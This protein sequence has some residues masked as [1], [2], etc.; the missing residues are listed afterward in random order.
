MSK[1]AQSVHFDLDGGGSDKA[2]REEDNGP[3]TSTSISEGASIVPPPLI[4]RRATRRDYAKF[5]TVH[6]TPLRPNWEPGQEPGLDPTKPNGGRPDGP[7]LHE[8][9]Q[10]TVVDYTSD[11][12][13]MHDF[14]NN[15]LIA[16]L[17]K[18]Q[19]SWVKCRWINVN[20]LSWDVIQCIGR[21][22]KLHRLAIEDLVSGKSLTKTEW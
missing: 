11:D 4:R 2:P 13:V 9:C 20:G 19:E 22:K 7:T 3:A 16:F 15:Q 21:Y 17:E 10:I 5:R 6:T 18:E 14:D 12:M 8:R 1:S